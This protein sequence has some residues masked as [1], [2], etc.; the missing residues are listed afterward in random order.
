MGNFNRENKL[1][2]AGKFL[3]GS[4]QEDSFQRIPWDKDLGIMK[5]ARNG[6]QGS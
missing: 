3:G 4:V 5:I 2:Q 1:F 6:D